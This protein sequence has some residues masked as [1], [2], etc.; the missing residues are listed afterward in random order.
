LFD[1]LVLTRAVHIA[2]TL[3]AAGTVT[4]LALAAGPALRA[5]AEAADIAAFRRRCDR[6]AGWALVVA[7]L[8][9]AVW[10]AL[11]S[12]AILDKPGLQVVLHGGALSVAG[13]TR[14]RCGLRCCCCAAPRGAGRRPSPAPLRR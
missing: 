10:L 4:F 7:V 5:A 14:W 11:I 9:G 3:L 6:L 13:G 12:A 8:S 1:P 2:A